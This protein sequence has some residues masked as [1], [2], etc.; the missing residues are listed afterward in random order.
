MDN[1]VRLP[2][3]VSNPNITV[4]LPPATA[5]CA[6]CAAGRFVLLERA[7]LVI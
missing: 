5:A 4:S 7:R 2:A 6:D 1:V 3:D